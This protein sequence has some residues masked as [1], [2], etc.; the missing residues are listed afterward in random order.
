MGKHSPIAAAPRY[1]QEFRCAGS[2][3]PENCCTGWT[4]T[5]DKPSY[6]QYREVKLEPLATLLHDSLERTPE[7]GSN[8][9]YARIRMQ[10]DGRCP[11][12]D[13]SR[14]C[15]IHGQL[16]EKALSDTCSN[17]PRFYGMDG[18]SHRAHAT[19]SCPEAARLALTH[20]EALDLVAMPL[21]FPNA[22]LVPLSARRPASAPQEPDP[23]RKHAA[24]IA[25]AVQALVRWP[26]FTAA[27]ALVQ[28]GMLLRAVARIEARGEAGE[29]ALSEVMG[30][31]L[32]PGHLAQAPAMLA[33]LP[34]PREAQLSLLFDTTQRYLAAH[35]GRPSFRQL[36]LEVQEGLQLGE[37]G[38]LPAE[39]LEAAARQRWAPLEAAQ[40]HLLKNY[41]L[42]DL[43]RSLFPRRG[44]AELERDFMSLAVRF[45]LIKL[46]LIGLAARRGDDFGVEDV[47]R[48]VYVVVRNIEHNAS[49]MKTVLDDLEARD[50]LR[51]EVLATM[52]L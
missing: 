46:F 26:A 32:D 35:H 9:A 16:G 10:P 19:L 52:V 3:C 25:E 4:V 50:A 2:N 27:Q 31:Y 45:A 33:Q 14:L 42:N 20:P 51:L 29:L 1:L 47:V 5:I 11:M 38:G 44:I 43:G 8:T 23:V 28:A 12:L 34:A 24:L 6:Q 18:S 41:L 36:I 17:Y 37:A 48:V 49:F 39:R 30:Q 21:P 15:R 22:H 7:E 13:E 40:P